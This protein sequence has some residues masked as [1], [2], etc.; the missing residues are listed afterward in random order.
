MALLKDSLITGDLRVTGTI[1]GNAT[2][3]NKLATARTIQTNLASTNSA[4]FNGTGN[5]TPGVS[6]ILG[7]ANGGTGNSL[8][9]PHG[10][11]A[12]SDNAT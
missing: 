7:I 11:S 12:R 9:I 5:I 4:S 2:S 1:Y 3:A 10:F 8:G 6:G